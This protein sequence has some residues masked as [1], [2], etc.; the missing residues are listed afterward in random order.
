MPKRK[1]KTTKDR[2]FRERTASKKCLT[3]RMVQA[4]PE[5]GNTGGRRERQFFCEGE[6]RRRKKLDELKRAVK[7]DAGERRK[8]NR[9][10][11][12]WRTQL[13]GGPQPICLGGKSPR[14]QKGALNQGGPLEKTN[15]SALRPTAMT[16]KTCKA[17]NGK[18]E[19]TVL[20]AD[21]LPCEKVQS[22]LLTSG[23]KEKEGSTTYRG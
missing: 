13:S 6:M 9:F 1:E 10:R 16:A 15:R 2:R 14:F 8:K 20:P 5:K 22:A 18:R 17:P 12:V 4:T 23:K 7:L 11:A 21:G 19:G 3:P